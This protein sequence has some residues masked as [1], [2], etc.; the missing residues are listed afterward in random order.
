MRKVLVVLIAFSLLG[1]APANSATVKAGAKCSKHKATTTVKG[2]KYTC[3]KSGNKLVW[4]KGMA[5]KKA[6][7]LQQGVCPPKA[8]ADQDPGITQIRANTLNGMS[9]MAAEK[10]AMSLDWLYR[11]GQRDEELFAGTFDFRIDRVTVKVMK[12]VVTEVFVG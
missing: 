6:A 11:V 9:E 2:M 3:I 7:V 12:G 8:A 10:C 4:S 1:I 5:V